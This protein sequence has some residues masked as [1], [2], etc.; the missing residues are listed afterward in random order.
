MPRSK[1]NRAFEL[2]KGLKGNLLTTVHRFSC[3]NK[4][5]YLKLYLIDEQNSEINFQRWLKKNCFKG[6]HIFQILTF[7]KYVEE[8]LLSS[9]WIVLPSG[10]AI[11]IYN[12][13]F[14]LAGIM[15]DLPAVGENWM[16]T[17]GEGS[18]K[19]QLAS[20]Q[21]HSKIAFSPDPPLISRNTCSR[22]NR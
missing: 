1:T 3:L 10:K 11:R 20:S 12:M 2:Q 21:D 6:T 16:D 8:A 13:R 14:A 5:L 9:S 19:A 18:P 15:A 22:T 4:V 17:L 7:V